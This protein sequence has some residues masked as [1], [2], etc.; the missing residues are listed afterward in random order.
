M[1]PVVKVCRVIT[2]SRSCC[3]DVTVSISPLSFFLSW[4]VKTHWQLKYIKENVITFDGFL[5]MVDPIVGLSLVI[6]A[7]TGMK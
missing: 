7:N 2:V 6:R 5:L 1:V 4:A 3:V